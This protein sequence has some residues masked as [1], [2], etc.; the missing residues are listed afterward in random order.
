LACFDLLSSF[1]FSFSICQKM[2]KTV[3]AG[4]QS[5]NVGSKRLTEPYWTDKSGGI[6][7]ININ[8][9]GTPR[10]DCSSNCTLSLLKE[11]LKVKEKEPLVPRVQSLEVRNDH[12]SR[13]SAPYAASTG[14][15]DNTSTP[16]AP[17]AFS[18]CDLHDLLPSTSVQTGPFVGVTSPGSNSSGEVGT[19]HRIDPNFDTSEESPTHDKAL[20][21]FFS[22]RLEISIENTKVY[23]IY[24]AY[25]AWLESSLRWKSVYNQ[26]LKN[27]AFLTALRNLLP[28]EQQYLVSRTYA[29]FVL[30]LLPTVSSLKELVVKQLIANL[31]VWF[32]IW[33]SEEIQRLPLDLRAWVLEKGVELGPPGLLARTYSVYVEPLERLKASNWSIGDVVEIEQT[34]RKGNR[35]NVNIK[36]QKI[37]KEEIKLKEKKEMKKVL[38]NGDESK[39]LLERMRI[40]LSPAEKN[41]NSLQKLP[42]D[43][44]DKAIKNQLNEYWLPTLERYWGS[45]ERFIYYFWKTEQGKEAITAFIASDEP[46]VQTMLRERMEEFVKPKIQ[47]WRDKV[48]QHYDTHAVE[49]LKGLFQSESSYQ[50]Q[51]ELLLMEKAQRKVTGVR[52]RPR[53]SKL[54]IHLKKA[55]DIDILSEA[56]AQ[57]VRKA[58]GG[59]VTSKWNGPY[60]ISQVEGEYDKIKQSCTPEVKSTT[61]AREFIRTATH[62]NRQRY[63]GSWNIGLYLHYWKNKDKE[64]YKKRLEYLFDKRKELEEIVKGPNQSKRQAWMSF[65]SSCPQELQCQDLDPFLAFKWFRYKISPLARRKLEYIDEV[66]ICGMPALKTV[67]REL[68]RLAV[69]QWNSKNTSYEGLV[70]LPELVDKFRGGALPDRANL[71][72]VYH[73]RRSNWRGSVSGKIY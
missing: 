69:G 45:L 19:A 20:Q 36:K 14:D 29:P 47:E 56:V 57:V 51:R 42:V 37:V 8:F 49:V 26:K 65:L 7:Y 5:C 43:L 68:Q 1:L 24:N 46:A 3:Q 55:G 28:K 31:E 70:S 34:K 2:M 53:S 48:Q 25:K 11:S 39:G 32:S 67:K 73:R 22:Q 50:Q 58:G 60:F 63:I 23:T 13:P 66:P 17:N 59:F 18:T 41:S 54:P 64:L 10:S 71:P 33:E 12:T 35:E 9:E 16:S 6:H 72:Y 27:N 52:S 61:T 15:C 44:Q 40:F 21:V 38:L 62:D 30:K 4:E